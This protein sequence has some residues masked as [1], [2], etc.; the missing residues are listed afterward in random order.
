VKQ[1]NVVV[2]WIV[3]GFA[4]AL[5]VLDTAQPWWFVPLGMFAA[6]ILSPLYVK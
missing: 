3:I 2:L 1:E 5:V 6:I 4:L